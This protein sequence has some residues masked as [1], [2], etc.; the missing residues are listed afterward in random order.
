MC[1]TLPLSQ[2]L[3]SP[4]YNLIPEL[5]NS[6]VF[7]EKSSL[8]YLI[9]PMFFSFPFSMM[10]R[11][12]VMLDYCMQ[13]M[14]SVSSYF[15]VPLPLYKIVFPLYTSFCFA[16]SLHKLYDINQHFMWCASDLSC[17]PKN[18]SVFHILYTLF[19]IPIPDF[20]QGANHIIQCFSVCTDHHCGMHLLL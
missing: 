18:K 14:L 17:S 5:V 19:L 9:G 2:V 16:V 1:S 20:L 11:G 3:P 8:V 13:T 15:P 7:L 12:H 4:L 6:W 10:H